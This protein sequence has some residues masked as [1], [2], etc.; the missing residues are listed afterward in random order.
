[1]SPARVRL[2]GVAGASHQGV[3]RDARRGQRRPRADRGHEPIGPA[4]GPQSAAVAGGEVDPRRPSSSPQGSG[5][6]L[7]G[8]IRSPIV[9]IVRSPSSSR[10]TKARRCGS[11]RQAARTSSP[12][13]SS[14][15]LVRCPCS[16]S[17]SAVKKRQPPVSLAICTAATA[18]P[19]AAACQA[20]AAATISP[21]RGGRVTRANSVHSAWPTT[22]K[23]KTPGTLAAK[24]SSRYPGTRHRPAERRRLR[25]PRPL[26]GA[27]PQTRRKW[28]IDD[29]SR[30]DHH[31]RPLQRSARK[32]QRWV[33]GRP[34]RRSSRWTGRGQPAQ[35]GPAR[36]PAHGRQRRRRLDAGAGRRDRR[37]GGPPRPRA[38]PRAAADVSIGEAREA[39]GRYPGLEDGPFSRCFVCG[40]G[41]ED[42]LGVFAGARRLRPRRLAVDAGSDGPPERTAPWERSSSRRCS[43]ARPTSRSTTTRRR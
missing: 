37:H 20:S 38:R 36:S 10:K 35:P 3:E 15:A 11:G 34:A 21:G 25:W 27:I 33:L 17:P 2:A 42:A 24:W 13:A 4:G 9:V 16:S 14:A 6:S 32:R 41:R 1:M 29:H 26:R 31:R 43:T 23:R 40:R 7:S 8:I 19:P 39:A 30:P 18:P 12:I 28:L 22:A 5:S